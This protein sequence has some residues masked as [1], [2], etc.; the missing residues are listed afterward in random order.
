MDSCRIPRFVDLLWTIQQKKHVVKRTYLHTIIIS[1]TKVYSLDTLTHKFIH[2]L[3]SES[4]EFQMVVE[5]PIP[6]AK[7]AQCVKLGIISLTQ[8]FRNMK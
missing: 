6:S 3:Q 4:N 2:L 7:N 5:P 1:H 8:P